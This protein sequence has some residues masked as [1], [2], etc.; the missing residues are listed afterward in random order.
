MNTVYQIHNEKYKKYLR[1]KYLI[2]KYIELFKI[3]KIDMYANIIQRTMKKYFIKSVTNEDELSYINPVNRI[4]IGFTKSHTIRQKRKTSNDNQ[5]NH[6]TKKYKIIETNQLSEKS[7][8]ILIKK[9]EEPDTNENMDL[10]QMLFDAGLSMDEIDYNKSFLND[11]IKSTDQILIKNDND[12]KTNKHIIHQKDVM[13]YYVY[14]VDFLFKNR[15]N[16]L[17]IDDEKYYL[18]ENDIYRVEKAYDLVNG[19][20]PSSIKYLNDIEYDKSLCKDRVKKD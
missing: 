7:I 14:D 16:R 19:T 6:K 3:K 17:I 12:L 4:R 15:F 10:I 1:E 20:T 5:K 13:F 18:Q 8:D 11:I 2:N 9:N